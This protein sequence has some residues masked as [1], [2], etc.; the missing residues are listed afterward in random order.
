MVF[1]AVS[2]LRKKSPNTEICLF[3]IFPYFD[4]IGI[5]VCS[6]NTGKYEP[7]KTPYLDTF[8]AVSHFAKEFTPNK[9]SNRLPLEF[10]PASGV[11]FS[12]DDI[13]LVIRK[14]D[15]SIAHGH[16]KIRIRLLKLCDKNIFIPSHRIYT[17]CLENRVF[18]SIWKMVNLVP[19]HKNESKI[20]VK[21]FGPVSLLLI[22]G[23]KIAFL[24]SDELYPYLLSYW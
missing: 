14:L 12:E 9:N 3:R 19:I 11:K 1:Y 18:P 13:L 6:P 7:E 23:K 15:P 16:S 10:L 17:S 4:W 24:I 22:C 8:Y 21:N 2:P 20:F 5:S